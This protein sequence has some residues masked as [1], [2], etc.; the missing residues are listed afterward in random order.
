MSSTTGADEIGDR[1]GMT[2]YTD[3]ET[4]FGRLGAVEEAIAVLHWDAGDDA[5]GRRR[6]AIGAARDPARHRASTADRTRN[7]RSARRC[8][9]RS[10]GARAM[11][12]R[13]SA[14]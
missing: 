9:K 4:R 10:S 6:G 11:A 7:R 12:A 8:G 3:L 2:A 14:R 13:Q 5:A 1:G